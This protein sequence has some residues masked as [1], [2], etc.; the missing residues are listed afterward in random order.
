MST[1][2]LGAT[3]ERLRPF[4]NRARLVDTAVK[5]V[6]VP[7]PT[8]RAG[9]VSDRFAAM[10]TAEGFAVERPDG[11]YPEAPAVVTGLESGRPG[12]TLQF[13]GH[14]DTVHLPFVRPAV[15]GDR[16]TGSGS[17]DMKSGTAAAVEALR[18][19][20]ESGALA[21]GSVLLTAH[22]LHESPWGDGRQLDNLVR[23]G[24]VGDAVL[25]PE[26]L[27]DVLPVVGRGLAVW[28]VELRRGGP[29]IHEVMRPPGTP[30]VISA[31]AALV[32]E[33]DALAEQLAASRDTGAVPPD[34]D[35][36][37]PSVFIGQFH[38]GEIFNQSPQVCRLEG[39]RRWL[40]GT[41]RHAVERDFRALLERVAAGSRTEA[42]LE[43]FFTRDAFALDRGHPFVKTFQAAYEAGTGRPLPPGPKPFV[44][45]GNSFWALA[46]VPAI[47]HGPRSAGAHT[48]HEWVSID[49][50]ERV[51]LLY[52]ATAVAFCAGGE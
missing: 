22:D 16:I 23:A 1:N 36:G 51:A 21:G 35:P 15:E 32:R 47:T 6:E 11:G 9:E 3:L 49:D 46:G 38:A 44:D 14:L 20:R 30:S 8:G 5:L 41:D 29:P 17:C 28:K 26:P 18:I 45:D 10:L 7:S 2:S 34:I 24:Y 39:T 52:A 37:P 4:V 25:L 42:G 31:G 33:L 50:L 40:P 12:R 19:L 27:C 48:L 13:N 43:W